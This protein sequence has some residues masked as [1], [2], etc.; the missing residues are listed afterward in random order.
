MVLEREIIWEL[1]NVSLGR[2]STD[3]HIERAFLT[4]HS[5][6]K[7]A[8]IGEHHSGRKILLRAMSGLR[9][10]KSGQMKVLGHLCVAEENFEQ[11]W[12]R[13]FPREIRSK[14]GVSLDVEGL[15]SNVSVREGLEMLFRFRYGDHNAKLRLGARKVVESLCR[16]FNIESIVDKRPVNLSRTQRRLASLAR[17]FLS[18][19]RVVLL[20][21]PSDGVGELHF[22]LLEKAL[23]FIFETEERTVLLSTENFSLAS[24]YCTRW[25]VFE[26]G[27]IIFDGPSNDFIKM[28]HPLAEQASKILDSQAA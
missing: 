9:P 13:L 4:V 26:K 16:H 28:K 19:P 2:S 25:V 23:D 12:D 3:D 1:V 27:K 18:K 14:I 11:D 6:E 21:D 7:V 17:A 15:L 8:L 20:E 10:I 24:K 5:G 22:H